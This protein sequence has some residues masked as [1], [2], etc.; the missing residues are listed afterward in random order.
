MLLSEPRLHVLLLSHMFAIGC[1]YPCASSATIV[2]REVTLEA[3]AIIIEIVRT[4]SG[5]HTASHSVTPTTVLH[6]GPALAS[7]SGVY[8]VYF[9][10][11]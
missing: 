4:A 1:F 6:S 3:M 9:K 7:R 2:F 11:F 5:R 10:L 8:V